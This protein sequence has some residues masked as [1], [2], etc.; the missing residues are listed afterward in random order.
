MML[1]AVLFSLLSIVAGLSLS[2]QADL[3]AGPTIILAAGA[4]YLA[5]RCLAR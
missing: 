4:I 1:L 2:Y 5:T 3:A